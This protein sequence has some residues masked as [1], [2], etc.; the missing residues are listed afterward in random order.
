MKIK[1][2]D[3]KTFGMQNILRIAELNLLIQFA[4]QLEGELICTVTV[5]SSLAGKQIVLVE[6]RFDLVG[7][8]AVRHKYT[9]T[10]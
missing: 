9:A 3:I 7:L 10:L 1:I 4:Q 5:L 2:Q 8:S 6:N